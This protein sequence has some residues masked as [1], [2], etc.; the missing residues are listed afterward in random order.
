MFLLVAMG[1][2]GGGRMA[3]STRLQ[4]RFNLI[5]MTFPNVSLCYVFNSILELLKLTF[6]HCCHFITFYK[7][8]TYSLIRT[9]VFNNNC[10]V[11]SNIKYLHYTL[12]NELTMVRNLKSRESLVP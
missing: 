2:P 9:N 5:N 8:N 6:L 10:L 12:P 1:P 4:S 3:I 11:N 7:L